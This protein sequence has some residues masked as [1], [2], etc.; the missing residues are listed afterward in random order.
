MK[1]GK[2]NFK[3]GKGEYYGKET[4]MLFLKIVRI[5]ILNLRIYLMLSSYSS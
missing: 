1:F 5:S 4:K 3:V 2:E